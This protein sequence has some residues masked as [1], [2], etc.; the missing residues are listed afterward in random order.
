MAFSFGAARGSPAATSST[1]TPPAMSH[2]DEGA[3]VALSSDARY[4]HLYYCGRHLGR[5]AIP[6]SDDQCGPNNGPQCASCKRSQEAAGAREEGEDGYLRLPLADA[7]RLS[8]T[9]PSADDARR[10]AEDAE[11]ARVRRIRERKRKLGSRA[12][13][14]INLIGYLNS[15]VTLT[16]ALTLAVTLTLALTLTFNIAK[17]D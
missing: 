17:L 12:R 13:R 16:L 1:P 5:E 15:A 8:W 9:T 11:D 2:N 3:A 10:D 14:N 4:A 7:D 6:G